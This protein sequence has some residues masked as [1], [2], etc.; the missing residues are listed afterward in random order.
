MGTLLYVVTKAWSNCTDEKRKERL[1]ELK[2]TILENSVYIVDYRYRLKQKGFAVPDDWRGLGAAESNVSKY[3]N[4]IGKR[5]RSWSEMGLGAILTTLS[6][7]F[8]GN[9]SWSNFENLRRQSRMGLRSSGFRCRAHCTHHP[10]RFTRCKGG[11]FPC[12][13]TRNPGL[14]K[15]I[16]QPSKSAIW[17]NRTWLT[18]FWTE[19]LRPALSID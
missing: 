18:I 13:K 8:K 12:H 16:P 19:S 1:G 3:K 9:S 6:R 17:I 7:L 4:R 14:F 5:G 11:W 2:A 15:V 10:K